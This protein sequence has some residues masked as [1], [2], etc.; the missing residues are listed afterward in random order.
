M[1]PDYGLHRSQVDPEEKVRKRKAIDL[2]PMIVLDSERCVL[3]SRC[4]RFSAEVTGTERSC[5]SSI[6]ATMWS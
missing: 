5:S 3:C 2:G 1:H 4:V 6:A